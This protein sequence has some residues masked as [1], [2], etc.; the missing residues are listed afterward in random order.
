MY[1]ACKTMSREIDDDD[2]ID[3]IIKSKKWSTFWTDV[4]RHN[5][6]ARTSN[7]RSKCGELDWLFGYY[8]D[9][10]IFSII[11][12]FVIMLR[13]I[14]ILEILAST[15]SPI[16]SSLSCYQLEAS[17]VKCLSWSWWTQNLELQWADSH[18]HDFFLSRSLLPCIMAATDLDKIVFSSPKILLP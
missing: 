16:A 6:W 15:Q 17:W 4:T 14:I 8:T 13:V 9:F 5:I 12:V 11:T 18:C 1:H 7:K 3:D 10:K 2:V